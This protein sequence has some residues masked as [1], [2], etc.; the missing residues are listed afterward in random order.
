MFRM[1]LPVNR[2]SISVQPSQNTVDTVAV[3]HIHGGWT[4]TRRTKMQTHDTWKCALWGTLSLVAHAAWGSPYFVLLE[5]IKQWRILLEHKRPISWLRDIAFFIDVY[6]ASVHKAETGPAW[7]AHSFRA[8][9]LYYAAHFSTLSNIFHIINFLPSECIWVY[10]SAYLSIAHHT[11]AFIWFIFLHVPST[12]ISILSMN[13]TYI[14]M[15]QIIWTTNIHQI[16]R[17]ECGHK[18]E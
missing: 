1:C 4:N 16:H 11:I 3:L 9:A 8:T 18:I 7:N 12:M 10:T 5:W 15:Q 17:M 14:V 13:Y 2:V 6:I